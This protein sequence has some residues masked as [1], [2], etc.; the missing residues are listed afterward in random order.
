MRIGG[1]PECDF[2][3]SGFSDVVVASE[4]S[5]IGGLQVRKIDLEG[6]RFL[7][8]VVRVRVVVAPEKDALAAIIDA[9]HG[10]ILLWSPSHA[11]VHVAESHV[12][13]TALRQG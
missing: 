2:V 13:S 10:D 12:P 4:L 5:S 1:R 6:R 7:N 11:V 3:Q 9:L 8:H